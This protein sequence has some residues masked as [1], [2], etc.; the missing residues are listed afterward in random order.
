V[1]LAEFVA[2][3]LLVAATPFAT[4]QSKAGLS[5]Y[6]GKDLLQLMAI[7]LTYFLLA[8]V[9][10]TSREAGRYAAWFGGLILLTVGLSE[11]AHLAKVV[12]LL[13]IGTGKKQQQAETTADQE[14]SG[15]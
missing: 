12:D 7:T 2:A 6:V 1:I 9:S 13:G 5:P 10:A 14:T 3:V 15:A 4:K 8:L 11:A